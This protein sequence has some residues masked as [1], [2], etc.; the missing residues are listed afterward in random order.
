MVDTTESKYPKYIELAISKGAIE[1]KIIDTSTIK[2]AAWT[3][4]KCQYGC[5]HY[6][7]NL[8]CPPHAPTSEETQKAIDE[9]SFAILACFKSLDD[10]DKCIMEIEREIF[11]DGIGGE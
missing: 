6:G 2:T 1:A 7:T 10:A 4:L 3:K 8:C 5:T 11:I 9:Y